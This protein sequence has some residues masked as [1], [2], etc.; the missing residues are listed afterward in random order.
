MIKGIATG[1]SALKLLEG[2]RKPKGYTLVKLF[3]KILILLYVSAYLKRKN[4]GTLLN[5]PVPLFKTSYI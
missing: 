2:R 5:I 1:R 4:S 3:Y